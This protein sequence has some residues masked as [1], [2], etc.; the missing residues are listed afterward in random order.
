MRCTIGTTVVMTGLVIAM[1]AFRPEVVNDPGLAQAQD[2]AKD[3]AAKDGAAKDDAGSA[4]P[5]KPKAK[6]VVGPG[7][8][9]HNEVA[10]EATLQK[11]DALISVAYTET[12]LGIALEAFSNQ[13]GAQ[14]HLDP[15]A[16][17]DLAITQDD[18]VTLGLKQVPAEMVLEL[19]LR[20]MQL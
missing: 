5:A 19:I 10:N 8:K 18:P 15:K 4:Q 3:D 16:L 20:R 12:P 11:L 2:T 13:L 14:F 1:L 9:S 7:G 6:A 17:V